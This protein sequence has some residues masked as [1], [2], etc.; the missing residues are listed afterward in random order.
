MFT[1]FFNPVVQI[2]GTII[3][4]RGF[5]IRHNKGIHVEH[6]TA[7]LLNFADDASGISPR[8]GFVK[9]LAINDGIRDHVALR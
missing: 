5:H 6:L 2:T 7:G 9:E 4:G 8:I 3:L 1:H